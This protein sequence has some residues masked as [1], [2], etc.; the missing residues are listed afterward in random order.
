M[1]PGPRY[2]PPSPIEALRI[3][4][5]TTAPSVAGSEQVG[6]GE[7]DHHRWMEADLDGP[8]PGERDLHDHA[9]QG[10]F[11]SERGRTRGCPAN[12]GR[13][14]RRRGPR[15]QSSGYGCRGSVTHPQP[16]SAGVALLAGRGSGRVFDAPMREDDDDVRPSRPCAAAMSAR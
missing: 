13:V 5:I 4:S 7:V 12:R 10:L 11:R 15:R 14:D 8:G 9:F 6:L 1:N 2:R 16:Q 3:R